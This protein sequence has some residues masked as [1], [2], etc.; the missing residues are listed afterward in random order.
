MPLAILVGPDT[1]GAAEIF[2]AALQANERA[3]I[4][5]AATPGEI[6]SET[7]FNLPDGSRLFITTSS[8]RTSDDRDVGLLGVIPDVAVEVD[9]DELTAEDDA[10]REAALRA[11][12]PGSG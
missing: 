11:L 6:E 5:G 2:S 9:W 7:S 4:V 10:V 8:F 1:T 3:L 12:E